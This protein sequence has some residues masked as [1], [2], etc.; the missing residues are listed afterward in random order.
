M[1]FSGIEKLKGL[2]SIL[3][4]DADY[5]AKFAKQIE[6]AAEEARIGEECDKCEQFV[7]DAILYWLECIP[8]LLFTPEKLLI[9]MKCRKEVH[10]LLNNLDGEP[11]SEIK[12]RVCKELVNSL[13]SAWPTLRIKTM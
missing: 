13:F 12:N 4:L 6:E 5:Q 9:G 1:D 8:P 3:K 10:K 7:V 2:A 11:R